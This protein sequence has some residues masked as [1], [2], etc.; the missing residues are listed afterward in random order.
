M[1]TITSTA[2]AALLIATLSVTAIAP[3]FAQETTPPAASSQDQA[4]KPGPGLRFQ[5][6]GGQ[7]G[8]G[9]L[10][11]FGRGAEG[12]EIALVRL[13]YRIELTTEQ[14]PLFDALRTAALD[15]AS[16]FETAVQ[17]LHPDPAATATAERPNPT[18]RLE[19]RIAIET[20]H[21]T[22]LEAVQ[23]AFTAFFD[24]LTDEQKAALTPERPDRPGQPGMFGKDGP[25]Q[26]QGQGQRPGQG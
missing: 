1:K 14:Q 6:Q 5:H 22:A 4:G 23:P 7:R 12:V 9:D 18:Q 2:V 20:A 11:D 15:A 26:H 17:G 25:R 16:S 8:G 13:S 24:S 10:L 19:N 3:A 21:L